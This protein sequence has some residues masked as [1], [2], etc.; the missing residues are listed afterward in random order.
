MNTQLL[1]AFTAVLHRLALR[2]DISFVILS[3]GPL[4][5]P[6]AAFCAGADIREMSNLKS[7]RE[8][9]GFIQNVHDACQAI[10][11]LPVVTIASIQG[12]TLGAGLEL[13]ASCDFRYATA[14]SLFGMP[15]TKLG[16]P[17]V[18]QARL[19]ANIV[20]WQKTKRLVYFGETYDAKAVHS[21]GLVDD[22]F[23][24]VEDLDRCV[25]EASK[26]VF[27]NG[28]EAMRAQ[29]RL[30][31][32]WEESG[33]VSGITAGIESF[34]DMFKDG[35]VEPKKYMHQFLERRKRTKELQDK[36]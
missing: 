11:D 4:P 14:N 9:E 21:W 28:P 25:A 16:I 10:R 20:G 7:A 8:A 13:A 22:V 24:S 3:G 15:E 19:L 5:N 2:D 1:K 26:S 34:A 32:L 17:S 23:D 35:G 6:K 27:R 36:R 29:K 30:V 33:L 18:V 12:L 31:R